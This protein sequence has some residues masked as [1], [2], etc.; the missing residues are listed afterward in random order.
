MNLERIE[1]IIPEEYHLERIDSFL[2]QS[3]EIDLSRSYIQKLIKLGCITVNGDIIKQKYK[4]KTDDKIDINIPAPEKLTIERENIPIDIVYEDNSIAI[5]H[6]P[7]GMVVHPGPGNWNGTLVNALLYHLKDLS[8]I[9][10]IIRPGIVHRL[11]KDTTGLMVI[12]KNDKSHKSIS[13]EFSKRAV[14]KRYSAV[15][16]EKP[17]NAQGIINKPIGRHPKY[18]HKMAIVSDG[19][20]SI[21]EYNLKKMW[22][23]GSGIFS[24]LEVFP[25]TGR[26]H[27]I[28]VHLSSI[29]N[30]IVGDPVYSKKWKSHKVPYLLLSSNYLEFTHPETE[31]RVHFEIPLP[32]HMQDFIQKIDSRAQIAF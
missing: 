14:V 20:E 25:H 8:S 21:T 5:I 26:T 24:F 15:I 32:K 11:D 12:A 3:L 17:K 6:K 2:A 22:N 30:P 7:P 28:R 10:G 18:R 16:V 23:T 9:G 13:E 27:Q 1:L 4:I 19:R 31:K 29:G